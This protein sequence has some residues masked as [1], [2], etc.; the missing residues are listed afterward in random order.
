MRAPLPLA[1]LLLGASPAAPRPAVPRI[2]SIN[3]CIDAIL[4]H[5]A[6]PA[7]IAG[8]SH[9]S[10]DPRATS[11]PLAQ[12]MRFTATSGTAE[13]VVALRPDVVMAT[14]PVAPATVA[15]LARMRV[16]LIQF[17]I[18]ASIAQSEAQ[19]RDVAAAAGHPARGTALAAA[20]DAAARPSKRPP[21][22]ALILSG[23]G[24]VPGGGT[25]ADEML[26]RAGF[27]NMSAGYGL[28]QWDILPLEYLIARPPRV[29]LSVGL[30]EARFDSG[31][32]DRLASHP[33]LA[34]LARRIVVAPYPTRLLNCGGPTIVAAMARLRA[35]R[36]GV[37]R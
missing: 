35:V 1:A 32:G 18:P 19:V 11:I 28:K 16:R 31:G 13:E 24:L 15:A 37:T 33:A 23:G 5:V 17:P 34:R 12:A 2:V 30:A 8:I 25:L 21:L 22:G 4:M 9:Y 3:P 26:T 6:D 20:I 7:Q 36:N 10:Q 27:R 29:L 14:A